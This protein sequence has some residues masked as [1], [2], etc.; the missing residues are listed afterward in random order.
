MV[1]MTD[2]SPLVSRG[3]T[4]AGSTEG[5]SGHLF[6]TFCGIDLCWTYGIV[7]QERYIKAIIMYYPPH[8]VCDLNTG[9]YGLVTISWYSP[10]PL[11]ID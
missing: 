10:T 7:G 2:T 6:L 4:K 9:T 5:D 1:S 11:T 8:S 3:S